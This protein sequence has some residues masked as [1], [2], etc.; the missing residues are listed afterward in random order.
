MAEKKNTNELFSTNK[1]KSLAKTPER[2]KTQVQ[3]QYSVVSFFVTPTS[4]I[5]YE[6]GALEVQKRKIPASQRKQLACLIAIDCN[7]FNVGK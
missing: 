2:N 1:G 7:S 4:S 6:E 3:Y 5:D